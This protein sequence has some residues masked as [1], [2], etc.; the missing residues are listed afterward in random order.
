MNDA[1]KL[2][3]AWL[4]SGKAGHYDAA[5]SGECIRAAWA[6]SGLQ[7]SV[8]DFETELR[9]YGFIPDNIRNARDNNLAVFRLVLPSAAS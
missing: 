9:G 3:R 2:V 6:A 5:T 4:R 8:T 7:I 1:S